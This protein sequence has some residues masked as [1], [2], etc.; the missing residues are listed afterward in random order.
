M[1]GMDQRLADLGMAHWFEEHAE[2]PQG[3]GLYMF[4]AEDVEQLLDIIGNQADT[5]YSKNQD[6]NRFAAIRRCCSF[7]RCCF[8]MTGEGEEEHAPTVI[9]I[10]VESICYATV[11]SGIDIRAAIDDMVANDYT[12]K[13]EAASDPP[14]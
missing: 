5:I 10:P 14:T 7:N 12:P 6:S 11:G 1:P 2:D 3:N 13:K 9:G 8:V 4:S